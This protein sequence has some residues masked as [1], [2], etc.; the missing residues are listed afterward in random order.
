MWSRALGLNV[1]LVVGG[2]GC[3]RVSGQA[4]DQYAK[5]PIV[6]DHFTTVY[7]EHADGTGIRTTTAVARIQSDAALKQVSVLTVGFAA[8]SEHAEWMYARLRHADGTVTETPVANAIEVTEPVTREAPTYSDLKELQLPLKDLRVGDRLEWQ[9]R[10]TKTRAEVEKQFWGQQ[11]F[12]V[13]G[14]VLDEQ[15]ELR[16]PQTA[17]VNVWS[18]KLA[19]TTTTEGAEKVYRWKTS[20]KEPTEGP[21]AEAKA[22]AEKKRVRSEAEQ[23]EAREGK[24]PDVAWTTFHSWPE[25]GEWYH[26]LSGPR[27]VPDAAIQ[28][29]VAQLTAGKTTER[30]KVQAVYAY[31]ATQIHY[32]GVSF[33]VGRYQPH[34][35]ANVLENQYGDCK[36]KHTLLASMLLV[37]GLKPEAV[38]MGA[39][40][41]FNEAVPSPAAFNH[42]LT[43]VTVA[44]PDGKSEPVW[45]DTTAEL[46]PYGMLV[47][48]TRGH[49]GLVIP[50]GGEAKVERAPKGLP[51]PAKVTLEATGKLD[52]EGTSN[53]RLT[54]TFRGDDELVLRGVLRQLSPAQYEQFAQQL[55]SNMGY[56]GTV[57]R[58]ETSRADDTTEPLRLSFDYKRSKAGDWANYKAIPQLLP[59]P[60]PRIDDKDP[61]VQAVELGIPRVEM[62]SAAMTLPEGW[63][64][65]M[66]EAIHL[67]SEWAT[68]DLTYRFEKGVM[69]SERRVEILKER[70]AVADF[71]TWDKFAEKAGREEFVQM[72]PALVKT[73]ESKLAEAKGAG[74]EGAA[75]QTVGP[76]TAGDAKPE[77]MIEQA[78][79]AMMRNDLP[80]AQ[81][82][83]D[84]VRGMN[85]EQPR[86][87]G[88]Y[89]FLSFRKG[90]ISDALVDYEKE[91]KLHPD[92]VGVYPLMVGA[93]L[94][95][96]H[97]DEALATL[98]RWQ[99]A[100]PGDAH[101]RAAVAG[102]LLEDKKYEEAASAAKAGLERTPDDDEMKDSLRMILGRADMKLGRKEEARASLVAALNHTENP[103]MMNNAAYELADAGLELPL[104]ETKVRTALTTMEEQSRNWTLGESALTLRAASAMLQA[105][106]D[107]LGWIYF[108]EGKLNEAE[109]YI[110][111]SWTGRQ[112]LDVGKHLG[113]IQ[114][115][116]GR[117]GEALA[118]YQLAL[119]SAPVTD[120]MGVHTEP[121]AEQKD[122]MARVEALRKGSGAASRTSLE[123]MRK[124]PL[125]KGA[126]GVAEYE[127]LVS[128]LGLMKEQ[129]TGEK[130]VADAALKL[131]RMKTAAF[132]PPGSQGQLML[133]VILNCHSGECE[134]VLEP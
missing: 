46:A 41:R 16:V 126:N 55:C 14:V 112:S 124:I 82:I 85:P 81:A 37:L 4:A 115:A 38:L 97:K 60:F 70:V 113:E 102:M 19:P 11:A 117:K 103:G 86:L 58:V 25:V 107:T 105:T 101:P 127:V 27:A 28:S 76:G 87:W 98:R 2:L 32:I 89:G 106:W 90:Q 116:R 121:T 62:S 45:L 92:T 34:S 50:L 59:L 64:A 99:E 40:I 125:G 88:M 110:R 15:V 96:K 51:F 66:P 9:T 94:A 108:R 6:M 75:L 100:A 73:G 57:S 63:K 33:G 47:Y 80:R 77:E 123:E 42:L 35:A 53:S 52:A 72:R 48:P 111:A 67:K 118:T 131:V 12:I 128:P 56:I 18:P 95:L 122:V 43:R 31:V 21:E 120:M 114:A 29:K 44:G 79:Q 10:V 13:N 22:A 134:A 109:A 8:N 30:E 39:G 84:R 68:D 65:D 74:S 69:Y 93:Q 26:G 36:D 24:L 71:K 3:L 23:E 54:M 91:L 130:T 132:F 83:L 119:A 133:M 78:N 20:H 1:L 104:T 49:E 17:Y 7:T 129:P 61:P 5:E